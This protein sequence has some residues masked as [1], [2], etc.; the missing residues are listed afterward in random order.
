[1]RRLPWPPLLVAT[2][3]CTSPTGFS[4]LPPPGPATP[5]TD[6]ARSTRA[7]ATAPFAIAIAVSLLIAPCA[8]RVASGTPRSSIFAAFEYVTKPRSTTSDAPAIAVNA[9]TT[10]PPVQLSAVAICQPRRRQASSTAVASS[11][12]SRSNTNHSFGDSDEDQSVKRGH[13]IVEHDAEPA[14]YV[15]VAP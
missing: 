13:D 10:S 15:A 6:T 9:A 11:M 7:R 12:V 14:L 5:V 1:M 8:A 4:A 3:K 2:A